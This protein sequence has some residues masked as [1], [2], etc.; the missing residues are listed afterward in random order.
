M[1]WIGRPVAEISPLEIFLTWRWPQSWICANVNSAVRSAVSKNP[2]LK[3]NMKWIGSPVAE[4]WPFA[5]IGGTWNPHFGGRGD[6]RGSAMAPL[7]RA[8]VVSYRLSIVTLA[9]SI[10]IR[11]QFAIECEWVSEQCFTSP[12]TQ[13]RLYG[14]RFLQVKRPNQQYQSTEGDAQINREVGHF[15]PKF[16]GVPIGVDPWCLG[17]QRANIPGYL[18][19]KLFRMYSNLCDHNPPTLQTDGLTDGQTDNMQ[20]QYRALH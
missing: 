17:L 19:V 7:E 14:R 15:R 20:W 2:T 10:T 5:Y 9:L 8:M 3:P 1:K 6:R 12:P 11:L 4:I 18:M 16:P 13:Y